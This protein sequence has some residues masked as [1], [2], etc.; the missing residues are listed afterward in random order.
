MIVYTSGSDSPEIRAMRFEE[1]SGTFTLLHTTD[2]G[3]G[4]GYLA[5]S[6]DGA[7]LFAI[8]RTPARL[9]AFAVGEPAELR[10]INEVTTDGV[11]GSTHL[12]VHPQGRLLMAA[13][14]GSGHV[15]VHP[16]D[17]GGAVGPAV[18]VQAT[19][20]E[21]HQ[22]VF[23]RDGRFLFVP[24][25]SGDVV[26]Q[27]VVDPATGKLARNDPFM[28]PARPGAGPR[29]MAVHPSQRFAFVLNELDG[30]MTSCRLDPTR[31]RLEPLATVP[32]VPAG[33]AEHAA[34]HI[35]V[36]PG[37]RLVYA[38]NREH[39]SIALWAFDPE[40]G[41][42]QLVGHETAGGRIRSPRD[43]TLTRD[44]RIM[45][46]A[47]Q[48]GGLL[49]AFRIEADG[50]LRLTATGQAQSAPTFIGVLPRAASFP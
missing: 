22:V 38:S 24:C 40:G 26:C 1:Q 39:G 31:G 47:N 17:A 37:G 7:F 6:A 3:P 12:A 23:T 18:D 2:A 20:R 11:L 46:V 48:A 15:S 35:E 32:S 45:L 5:F 8:N 9:R 43:F 30:T 44:G 28:V 19:G 16:L 10:L 41:G 13:H 36:H 34:A 21:A 27:F 14:F 25:R 42:L 50:T 29:H 49:L 33:F 4:S